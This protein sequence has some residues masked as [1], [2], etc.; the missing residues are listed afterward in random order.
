MANELFKNF[1]D[2]GAFLQSYI[3]AEIERCVKEKTEFAELASTTSGDEPYELSTQEAAD[4]LSCGKD[5]VLEYVHSGV[6]RGCFLKHGSVFK[7]KRRATL[8]ALEMNSEREI[9]GDALSDNDHRQ[10]SQTIT[11]N[12]VVREMPQRKSA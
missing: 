4:L 12:R 11:K 6:L 7:F 2:I 10:K 8:R 3:D 9:Y 1:G 5:K